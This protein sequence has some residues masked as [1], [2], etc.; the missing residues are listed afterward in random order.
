MTIDFSVFNNI[1]FTNRD[2]IIFLFIFL[3]IVLII[4]VI[5]ITVI[6][7]IIKAIKLVVINT[8]NLD[9]KKPKFDQG[10]GAG[11][12]HQSQGTTG[13]NNMTKTKIAGGDSIKS[14]DEEKKSGEQAIDV[15]KAKEEKTKKGILARLLKLKSANSA[16]KNTLE[17]KMPSRVEKPEDDFYKGIKVPQSSDFIAKQD[18]ENAVAAKGGSRTSKKEETKTKNSAIFKGSSEVSRTKLKHEMRTNPKI[19]QASKQAGLNLSPLERA[20]LVKDVFPARLGKDISQA[21]LRWSVKKLNRKLVS[22]KNPVE[23]TQLRKKIKFI[24]KIGGLK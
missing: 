9:A 5:I 22:E 8:F 16:N 24:K 3:V 11:W 19:W 10:G 7:K 17:S 2:N 20:N 15:E 14:L 1:D 12:P 4:F 23:H 6:A 13:A 18:K 21:D